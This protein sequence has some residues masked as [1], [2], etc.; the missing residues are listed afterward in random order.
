V[1]RERA[2][3]RAAIEAERARAARAHRR[4]AERTRRRREALTS[5]RARLPRRTRWRGPRGQLARRRRVENGL[6]AAA[7]LLT[8]V[9][10]WLV[11]ADWWQRLGSAV[12]AVLA[13]PVL[14]TLVLDRRA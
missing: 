13:L 7:F 5:A 3:R 14:V 11:T 6:I 8:Q 2:R 10:T 1:S 4:R 9:L 12:L